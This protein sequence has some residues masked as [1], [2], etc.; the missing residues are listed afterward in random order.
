MKTWLHHIALPIIAIMIYSCSNLRKIPKG[1]AL[2][3]GVTVKVEDS[4]MN[5]REKRNMAKELVTL[6]RPQPNTKTF[7]MRIKLWAYNYLPK[8]IGRKLGEEPVLLSRV[9]LNHNSRV[10]QTGLEN[11]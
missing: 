1:D 8:S 11:K 5:G 7:G 3:V 4:L 9:D 6:T 10:L 2:F